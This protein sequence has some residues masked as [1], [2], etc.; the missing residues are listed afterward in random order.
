MFADL[1]LA[2]MKYVVQAGGQKAE[3]NHVCVDL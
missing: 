3:N 1:L 2:L